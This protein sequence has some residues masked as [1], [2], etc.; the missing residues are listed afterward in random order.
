[1]ALRAEDYEKRSVSNNFRRTITYSPNQGD[2]GKSV[3]PGTNPAAPRAAPVQMRVNATSSNTTV[4][5][6]NSNHMLDESREIATVVRNQDIN[7][8]SV[9][10]N[11]M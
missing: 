10:S 4:Q 3:I 6:Q 5:Q 1:M 2:K 11:D 7:L 8:T 9:R